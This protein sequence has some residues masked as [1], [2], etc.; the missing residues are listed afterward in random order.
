MKKTSV[1][2]LVMVCLIFISACTPNDAPVL[3]ADVTEKAEQSS[4]APVTDHAADVPVTAARAETQTE[5]ETEPF[6]VTAES[7][8]KSETASGI[9]EFL[10]GDPRLTVFHNDES[11]AL[12]AVDFYAGFD[13]LY[14][15]A[16]TEEKK[17]DFIKWMY[18]DGNVP[19][20]IHEGF[21][22]YLPI[23]YWWIKY[24]N[25]DEDVIRQKAA[26]KRKT[27]I[28]AYTESE[29][30]DN[31]LSDEDVTVLY[32]GTEDEI[33]RH[34][35]LPFSYVYGEKVYSIDDMTELM[36]NPEGELSQMPSDF[37]EGYKEQVFEDLRTFGRLYNFI[38]N[39]VNREGMYASGDTYRK[40]LDDL[41]TQDLSLD[42]V[43]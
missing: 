29:S 15:I 7:E 31:Y 8:P 40:M 13:L 2:A 43:E 6:A 37:I 18:P 3:T 24:L 17:Q 20:Y 19:K 5:P 42:T 34:F 23:V 9:C 25:I 38:G 12:F 33:R 41:F 14:G 26:E 32:H 27:L 28:N 21:S 1:I 30:Y 36:K 35:R 16:D 39:I 4:T 11:S 22:H 10:I